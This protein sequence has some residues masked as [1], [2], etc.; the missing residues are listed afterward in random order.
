[1]PC[2]QARHLGCCWWRFP[3]ACSSHGG[4]SRYLYCRRWTGP[5]RASSPEHPDEEC[6]RQCQGTIWTCGCP[7]APSRWGTS[8]LPVHRVPHH[9][10]T[11]PPPFLAWAEAARCWR[12]GWGAHIVRP[13]R[14]LPAYRSLRWGTCTPLAHPTQVCRRTSTTPSSSF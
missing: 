4:S 14:L 3:T 13:P 11:T 5:S 7:T 6:H 2:W 1:M 9:H 10:R 8:D 12:L